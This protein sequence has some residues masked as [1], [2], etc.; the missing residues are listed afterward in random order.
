MGNKTIF[1]F[2]GIQILQVIIAAI[3]GMAIQFAGGMV[4]G[5]AGGTFYSLMGIT[6]GTVIIF[7]ISRI[8][9]MKAVSLFIKEET[10]D[11]FKHL[12][13]GR[14]GSI[15]IFVMYLVPGLPKDVFTYILGISPVSAKKFFIYSTLGRLPGIIGSCIIGYT[16]ITKNYWVSGIILAVSAVICILC[17]IFKNKIIAFISRKNVV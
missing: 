15:V 12:A 2:S 11:K 13:D 16:Y 14:T 17:I 3:P 10:Y 8:F 1:I 6:I 7:Y 4:Y 5:V 9:G